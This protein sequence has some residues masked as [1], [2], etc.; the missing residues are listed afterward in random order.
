MFRTASYLLC[1]LL[2]AGCQKEIA[3]S[4]LPQHTAP[5]VLPAPTTGFVQYTI[6]AGEHFCD[7]NDLKLLETDQLKFLVRFDSSAIYETVDPA[8]QDDINKLYGFSDNGAQ[9]HQFS[10]RFG[11]RWSAGALRLFGYVYNNSLLISKEISTVPIGEAV[12]C[13]LE[14]TPAHYRFTVGNKK[15]SLPRLSTTPKAKGYQLYPY[16]GGD[17]PAPHAILIQIKEN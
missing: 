14:V 12:N 7:K 3:S 9:H 15:D 8:N 4:S 2:F 1:L 13:E 5:I 16:F 17:E 6:K 10:A 11:W